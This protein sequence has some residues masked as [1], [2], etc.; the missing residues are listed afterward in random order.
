[1]FI[2][3]HH[4]DHANR[5][6]SQFNSCGSVPMS[7]CTMGKSSAGG[8]GQWCVSKCGWR[9]Q[10]GYIIIIKIDSI[11]AL[12]IRSAFCYM[13]GKAFYSVWLWVKNE[14]GVVWFLMY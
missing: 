11:V 4:N 13:Q 8:G 10:K 9:Q 12:C 6:I 1:M 2:L 7:H 14:G 5:M 3:N